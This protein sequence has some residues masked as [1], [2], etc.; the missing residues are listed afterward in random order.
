MELN[1]KIALVTGAGSG[2]GQAIAITLAKLG[3]KVVVTD[4]TTDLAS[5]TVQLIHEQKGFAISYA[6]NVCDPDQIAHVRDQLVGQQLAPN[7]LVN[8]A[9]WTTSQSFMKN[10]PDL[11]DKLIDINLM[12]VIRVTR[13]FLEPMVQSEKG[14]SVVNVSSDAGRVG[15]SGESVYAAAKGGVIA[16][17]KSLAREMTRY[18]INVNCVCPGPT[19]TQLLRSNPENYIDALLKAI[20]MKRFAD[21][22]DIAH[23]VAYFASEPASY[24]TGQVMSVS[25][26]LTMV[27]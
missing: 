26:G 3:A 11:W 4:M 25:G 23:A 18:K 22:T 6:M 10:P 8:N 7:V 9:G 24:V 16:L 17:S 13:A 14:G 27:G 21:P 20:P 15:S 5:K 2:I 1:S 12:G 19:E